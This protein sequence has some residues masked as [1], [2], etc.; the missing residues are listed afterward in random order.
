[1]YKVIKKNMN[2]KKKSPL[3]RRSFLKGSTLSFVA[4]TITV[5]GAS[6]YVFRADDTELLRPPGALDESTF[7]A[8]CIKCGQCVQVCPPQILDLAGLSKGFAIG[9][10]Y[11]T[12]REGACL[13]CKGLPCVLACPTGAL[14][15]DITEGKEA[16]MGLAVLRS[17]KTCLATKSVN[18]I[19]FGLE[20]LKTKED[21]IKIISEFLPRMDD[22]EKKALLEK[23][24]IEKLSDINEV[25]A[26][27]VSSQMQSESDFNWFKDLVKNSKQ[28]ETSCRICLDKC[29][30]KEEKPIVFSKT[31]AAHI[32]VFQESC[33]GCGVCEMECP[34]EDSCITI[35]PR[36]T[37]KE[38]V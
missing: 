6:Q 32:P 26:K 28:A 23:F 31:S 8:S 21:R 33:V 1:M 17:P 14:D 11:L 29:P 36:L 7:L 24:N 16:E 5:G 20:N 27:L 12:P 22:L 18:D 10:P 38:K 15:H 3:S 34:T 35:I 9:T 37:Y 19:V 2:K 13:L 4:G 30:I 25:N